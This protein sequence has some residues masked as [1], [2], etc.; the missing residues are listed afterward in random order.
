[1]RGGI[2]RC[3]ALARVR[4]SFGAIY[5]DVCCHK[6]IYSLFTLVR[7]RFRD[8]KT[9][10][11]AVIKRLVRVCSSMAAVQGPPCSTHTLWLHV[12]RLWTDPLC[13]QP[14]LFGVADATVAIFTLTDLKEEWARPLPLVFCLLLRRGLALAPLLNETCLL[15]LVDGQL[16]L[17]CGGRRCK[18]AAAWE[19][20]TTSR[21]V[22]AFLRGNPSFSR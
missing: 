16:T 10:Q 9:D 18:T 14:G 6:A 7:P 15:Y 20:S 5:Y 19:P 2:C 1:M 12:L 3:Q 17:T 11:Y 8:L 22:N 4:S 13:Q 21:C